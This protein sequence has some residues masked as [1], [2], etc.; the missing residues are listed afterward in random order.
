MKRG[1]G[2]LLT[3]KHEPKITGYLI[4]GNDHYEIIGQRMSAIRTNLELRHTGE[5]E[6]RGDLSDGSSSDAGERKR[7]LV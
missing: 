4:I 3:S 2:V 5:T 7:G 6:T 1:R